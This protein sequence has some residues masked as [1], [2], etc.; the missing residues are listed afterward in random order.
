[1]LLRGKRAVIFLF[2]CTKIKGKKLVIKALKRRLNV[3][4]F[5]RSE[6]K[7]RGIMNKHSF[8]HRCDEQTK[9][10]ASEQKRSNK[11]TT[12]L[13]SK[14]SINSDSLL[15]GKRVLQLFY[16]YFV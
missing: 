7:T 5:T 13:T 9:A 11:N 15:G 8:V 10:A 1:M 2:L 14:Q 3:I 4:N 6:V 16:F 12:S